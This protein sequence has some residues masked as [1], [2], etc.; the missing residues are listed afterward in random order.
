MINGE[1][2]FERKSLG[3]RIKEI[4]SLSV[5]TIIVALAGIALMDIIVYP[6]VSFA[7]QDVNT[8]NIIFENLF[9]LFIL[10]FLIYSLVRKIR[11]LTREEAPRGQV[12]MY[13]LRR[14]FHYITLTLFILVV[15][16]AVIF[17]IYTLFSQNY[18]YLYKI[19]NGL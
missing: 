5:F 13:L 10:S 14:P 17:I 15:S 11:K 3:N 6:L 7:V 16:S 12:L 18:Y 9:F 4:S 2:K 19:S 1:N 8:F